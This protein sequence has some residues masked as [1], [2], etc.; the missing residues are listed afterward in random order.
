MYFAD[1]VNTSRDPLYFRAR[2]WKIRIFGNLET[3]PKASR[4]PKFPTRNGLQ[5]KAQCNARVCRDACFSCSVEGAPLHLGGVWGCVLLRSQITYRHG[6]TR[7]QYNGSR[8]SGKRGE[9]SC[10]SLKSELDQD[11]YVLRTELR[12]D[13]PAHVIVGVEPLKPF[14]RVPLHHCSR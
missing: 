11:T 8:G 7:A 1:P 5:K 14:W 2:F 4:L 13:K 10:D 12:R 6:G 3:L 9:K